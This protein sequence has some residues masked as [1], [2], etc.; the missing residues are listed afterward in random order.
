MEM[1]TLYYRLRE[2]IEEF[3]HSEENSKEE[4]NELVDV[5]N[6]ALMLATRLKKG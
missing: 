3:S 5:I 6:M 4:Y 1:S 2:E